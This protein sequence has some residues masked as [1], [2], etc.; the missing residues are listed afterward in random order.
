MDVK[1]DVERTQLQGAL[2][3][4]QGLFDSPL[5]HQE[6]RIPVV[7]VGVVGIQLEGSLEPSL[8]RRPIPIVEKCNVSQRRVGLAERV[9]NRERALRRLLRL[10]HGFSRSY[11]A[12]REDERRV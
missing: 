3:L 5:A 12:Q 1:Q 6:V 4:D 10:G 2:A 8:S 7:R 9:I 11:S